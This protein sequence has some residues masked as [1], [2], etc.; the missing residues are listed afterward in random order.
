LTRGHEIQA[1]LRENPVSSFIILDDDTDF[2][3]EQ[4]ERFVRCNNQVGL[5]AD[6]IA[7]CELLLP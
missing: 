2:L 6:E 7:L 1:W 3:P 5:T 4:M